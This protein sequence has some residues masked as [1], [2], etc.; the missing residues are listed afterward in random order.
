MRFLVQNQLPPATCQQYRDELQLSA[1]KDRLAGT[2][3]QSI[4]VDSSPVERLKELAI[5]VF[6][7][8]DKLTG[9]LLGHLDITRVELKLKLVHCSSRG[10]KRKLARGETRTVQKIATARQFIF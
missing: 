8:P 6:I 4:P 3:V 5:G 7:I 9:P 10:G 2:V 1:T